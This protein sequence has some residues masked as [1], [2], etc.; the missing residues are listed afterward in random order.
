MS[1]LRNLGLAVLILV[2]SAPVNAAIVGGTVG[3]IT[4]VWNY[5]DVGT[6][7]VVVMVTSPPATC[8]APDDRRGRQASV[9]GRACV[10]VYWRQRQRLWI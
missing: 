1:V 6:G 9:C 8:P 2:S 5:T 7:D 4:Q 3:S 10:S